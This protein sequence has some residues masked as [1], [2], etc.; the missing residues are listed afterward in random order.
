VP[1]KPLDDGKVMDVAKPGKSKPVSTSRP[2]VTTLGAVMGVDESQ[3]VAPTAAAKPIAPPSAA[4]RTIAPINNDVKPEDDFAEPAVE[5][6]EDAEGN[7]KEAASE[8]SEG[9]QSAEVDALAENVASKKEAEKIAEEQLKHDAA[10]QELVD[11]K[12]Y[13]VPLDHDSTKKKSGNMPVV[14]L[15]VILILALAGYAVVDLGIVKP[16]F[17][18]P[19]HVLKK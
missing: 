19:V 16:G 17:D 13:F 4:H 8:K 10:I 15:L 5:V 11:S 9:S 6:S 3:A 14:V 18:V 12:K 7:P 2:V 1:A